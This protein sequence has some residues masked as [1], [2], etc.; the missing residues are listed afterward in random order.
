MKEFDYFDLKKIEN[1]FKQVPENNSYMVQLKSKVVQEINKPQRELCILVN[2]S[3]NNISY[4]KRNEI[5]S[6]Q[7]NKNWYKLIKENKYPI[8]LHRDRIDFK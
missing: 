4:L 5:K 1:Y 6:S 7:I 3:R 2:C 8:R